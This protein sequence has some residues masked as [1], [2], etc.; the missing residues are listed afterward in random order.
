MMKGMVAAILVIVLGVAVFAIA[1]NDDDTADT[2]TASQAAVESPD[3]PLNISFNNLAPLE[4]GIY[5]GW[6]VRD[7]VKYSFGTFNTNEAGDVTS[8]FEFADS[9]FAPQEGDTVAISIEPVP[10]TDPEPSA[11]IVLAGAI[12]GGNATLAFPVDVS[13]FAGQ[14]ILATPTT[15]TEDDET[16]GL[17][18]FN[19]SDPGA[20]LDIP[21][22]PDGWAYEGW[23]VV[24]G[25]PISSGVFKD[26]GAPDLF[27]GFSGPNDGPPFPG[28]DFVANL[29]DG[30]TAP[31]DLRGATIV[32]S[33]EP[34]Q[35]GVDPTGPKPAQV[36][37][38][39][40]E[41]ASD[42]AVKTLFDLG[43]STESLPSGS[44]SL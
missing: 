29:P 27:S 33:I 30:F 43:V 40:G 1:G 10:D 12:E 22:A 6:V 26:P 37:P 3:F 8:A 7:D 24:N 35:G 16:A 23:A 38:L 21:V 2:S 28:E 14:Y 39:V 34:D 44:A 41:V 42:A 31:L 32:L 11:T 5:E 4:Q 20:T 17:W 15:T 19:P 18:F 13:G 25:M 9:T 36:K